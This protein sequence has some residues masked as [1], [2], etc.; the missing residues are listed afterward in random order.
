LLIGLPSSFSV[1]LRCDDTTPG[2]PPSGVLRFFPAQVANRS[3][4]YFPRLD[5]V[6]SCVHA[7]P[8]NIVPVFFASSRHPGLACL[9]RPGTWCSSSLSLSLGP[10]RSDLRTAPAISL[11]CP[12]ILSLSLGY[13]PLIPSGLG[14]RLLL[15]WAAVQRRSFGLRFRSRVPRPVSCGLSVGL[16][17]SVGLVR[18][19]FVVGGPP[20]LPGCGLSGH[21]FLHESGA[22]DQHL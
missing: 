6:E 19:F 12:V 21:A 7:H 8:R 2:R 4:I 17:V 15:G 3:A 10:A 9:V 22:R 13:A 18:A 20:K 11:G 16:G 5:A 14:S 1:P